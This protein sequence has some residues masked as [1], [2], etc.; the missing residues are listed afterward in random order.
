ML[1]PSTG[2]S[3]DTETSAGGE[4]HH[5]LH[6]DLD[7]FYAAV[8]QL[9][10]PELRGKAVLVGGRP[11]S[12]GVV[13]TASYEA[14]EYGVH[15]AMPMRTAAR[16]CPQGIIVR[17][18]FDRYREESQK[19]MAIFRDLSDL[20]EPLSLDEA[21]LDISNSVEAGSHP[22]AVAIALKKRV[23]EATGLTLSVGVG[24]SKS[25]AKIASD[26]QKP[27]GLVVVP[28]GEE[29]EFLA[30]LAVSRLWGV[31]PKTA[32]RLKS[33]GI[34][35][36]GQLA[37]R[38]LEWFQ[39]RFGQRAVEV[40]ARALGR[41]HRAVHS[42]RA[43]KSI[44]AETTF[45]EDTS[46][47]QELYGVVTRLSGRVAQ[48]LAS[49]EQRVKTVILKARLADFTTFTRQTTLPAAT[50]VE[51]TIVETARMLLSKELTTGRSF[52]LLGVGVSGFT[53]TAQLELPLVWGPETDEDGQRPAP[54][55]EG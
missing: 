30:P 36:I 15:S 55:S 3:G 45:A 48:Q 51:E 54:V 38:P 24:T 6:A 10:N 14:R 47:T 31:G 25:V 39:K 1:D 32:S 33:D 18:R 8:E 50:H 49:K 4:F 13:A 44:S 19:V 35:T 28:Q 42:H 7:A 40:Q 46:D 37:G 5:I 11:E 2:D 23:K 41:D 16:L 43:A 34:E 26:L 20:V 53:E 17:P 9:D 27:D 21:Y 22:L 52:R 12:R 29:R